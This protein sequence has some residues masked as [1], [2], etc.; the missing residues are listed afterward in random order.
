MPLEPSCLSGK[1]YAGLP[2]QR[3]N[4]SWF[5]TNLRLVLATLAVGNGGSDLSDFA[6]FLDLPQASSFGNRPFNRIEAIVGEHLRAV[7]DEAMKEAWEEETRLTL[8]AM[9]ESYFLWKNKRKKDRKNV[10]LTVSFDMGWQKRSSGNRYDSLSGHAFMI[11]ARSRKILM[12]IVSSKMC[13]TCLEGEDL[14]VNAKPHSCP[15][16]YSGSSKAMEADAALEA[17]EELY[18]M[19]QGTTTIGWIIADDDS[20]MRSLL[21]HPT[22]HHPKGALPERLPEPQWLAD[23]THRTKCMAKPFFALV[24]LGKTSTQCTRVDA[25]RI[26]QWWGYMIKYYR[27]YPIETVRKAAKAVVE[28]L[29]NDHR[30]CDIKWCKPL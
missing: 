7:S 8:E 5:E 17:Y 23:P 12:C 10:K 28:H 20:S 4:N 15:R 19:S 29:F 6:A 11:G 25:F 3:K 21:R 27:K 14:Q 24:A 18:E 16:N 1:S 30:F 26:K 22:I 13:A 2:S 9:G